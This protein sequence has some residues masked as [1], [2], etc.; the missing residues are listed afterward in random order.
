MAKDKKRVEL[1][2]NRSKPPREKG[3]KRTFQEHGDA[4][5]NVSGERQ[6]HRVRGQ[7]K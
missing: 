7:G 3:W 1:R 4:D 6:G 5:E 2:K